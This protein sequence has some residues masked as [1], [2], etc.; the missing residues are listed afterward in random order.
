M[1]R[2]PMQVEEEYWKKIKEIQKKIMKERGEYKGINKIQQ[3]MIM[4]PEWE[5]LE[6]RLIKNKIKKD[7]PIKFDGGLK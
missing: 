4:T 6:Q 2:R 3:E 5:Q 1:V 7:I